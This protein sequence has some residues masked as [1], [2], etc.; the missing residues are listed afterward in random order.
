MPGDRQPLRYVYDAEAEPS[1]S[2]W[3]DLELHAVPVTPRRCRDLP[4]PA[5]ARDDE[6]VDWAWSRRRCHY[7][8]LAGSGGLLCDFGGWRAWWLAVC[9][10]SRTV[11]TGASSRSGLSRRLRASV[12]SKHACPA[13]GP[14]S[15]E[16]LGRHWRAMGAFVCAAQAGGRGVPPQRCSGDLGPNDSGV[17][18]AAKKIGRGGEE[19]I[20]Q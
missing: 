5:P 6:S 18:Q 15:L 20:S 7:C 2:S 19:D 4:G 9:L 17:L 3:S 12:P 16:V 10:L 11:T 8:A 13:E 14:S 1:R